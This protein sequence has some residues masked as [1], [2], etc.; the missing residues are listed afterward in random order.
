MARMSRKKSLVAV[1]AVKHPRYDFRAT[2]RQGGERLQRFFRTKAEARAFAAEKEVE[3]LNLG[4][5]HGE[6]TE[7]ERRVVILAREKAEEYHG[8]GIAD[9][10]LETALRF[11][12][13]HLDNTRASIPTLEAFKRFS[14]AKERQ[15]MSDRYL[16]DIKHRVERFAKHFKGK[17]VSQITLADVTAYLNG[18]KLA[19]LTLA[20]HHRLIGVFLSWCRKQGLATHNAAE[21]WEVPRIKIKRPGILSVAEVRALLAAAPAEI[22]PAVAVGF[23]AGL[24]TSE[25]ARL[26]WAD[27]DFERLSIR[28]S[29]DGKTG[30]R[31]V[32][33]PKNL[34]A[35][36]EPH[37]KLAGPVGM[38][39]ETFYPRL[40]AA[41]TD[42]GIKSWP[43]NA[44]RHSCAS[45][46]MEL[47]AD[48]A[49]VAAS[50]GHSVAVLKKHYENLVRRGEGKAFFAI[51]PAKASNIIPMRRAAV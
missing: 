49:R 46:S 23:F 36:L 16:S 45:Y 14:D 15:R 39:N 22:V 50:L 1:K 11:Y 19:P 34:A 40:R 38:S 8:K 6:I 33:M 12:C 10:S 25:I 3:L 28:V 32:P 29:S 43:S 9:F 31:N 7:D 48:H 20:N 44:A 47:H 17:L 30:V 26:D 21:G 27:F 13:E 18:L 24:R 42:A 41:C 51:L 5:K 35:W 4:R 37:R 2:F